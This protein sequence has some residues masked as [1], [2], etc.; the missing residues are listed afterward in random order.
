MGV[1]QSGREDHVDGEQ[2]PVK[3][4]APGAQSGMVENEMREGVKATGASM[5]GWP[6]VV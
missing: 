5:S 4:S 1:E 2:W 6:Q 3:M